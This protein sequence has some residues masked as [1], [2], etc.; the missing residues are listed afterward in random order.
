MFN[1]LVFR[2]LKHK[3]DYQKIYTNI[4]AIRK[5]VPA[6]ILVEILP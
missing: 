6:L 5:P 2:I 3:K 4:Y 1:A